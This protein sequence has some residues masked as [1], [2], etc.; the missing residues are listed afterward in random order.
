MPA[1]FSV[2]EHV[3]DQE[4]DTVADILLRCL[5]LGV[6]EKSEALEHL[7]KVGLLVLF[8]GLFYILVE[9]WADL[10]H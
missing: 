3:L 6:H 1:G 4:F 7:F 9:H 2:G 8:L 5:V 10:I